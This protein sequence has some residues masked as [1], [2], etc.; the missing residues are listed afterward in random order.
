MCELKLSHHGVLVDDK[1][2]SPSPILLVVLNKPDK[3]S[4]RRL[5][6]ASV[7]RFREL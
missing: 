6:S 2:W 5:F 3:P 4:I 1:S 7:S